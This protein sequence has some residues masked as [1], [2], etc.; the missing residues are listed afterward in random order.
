MNDN[1]KTA[2]C[3]MEK[4]DNRMFNSVGSSRIRARWLL[5]VW[6]EAEEFMIGKD[7]EAVIFQ[8]VYWSAFMKEFKGVK[9][10]DLCDPDWLEGKPVLQFVD[11]ADATTT[12]TQALA[13]Y[14]LKL[15]PNAKVLCIPDRVWQPDH[16]PAKT[17]HEGEA[18]SVVW[19]G[20]AHNTH[21]LYKTFD[22]L[23]AK[24][25]S[26][27]IVSEKPFTPSLGYSNLQV[28]NVPFTYPG[29]NREITKHDIV[30]MPDPIEDERGKFKSNNK[31]LQAWACGMPVARLPEDLDRFMDPKE[32]QKE[33]D[34]RMKEINEKWDVSISVQEYKDLIDEIK[35]KK[36]SAK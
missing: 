24:K 12:S 22:D 33:S 5:E 6:P 17:V 20:Y 35:A 30:L 2:F 27:T 1:K 25:L 4:F 23:I 3:T 36:A 29:V 32:R 10:L 9:I 13:D 18:R 34:L 15:R 7:Y 11:M 16:R 28:Y 21:Y 19:F 31:T 14:I 26:L 8:K